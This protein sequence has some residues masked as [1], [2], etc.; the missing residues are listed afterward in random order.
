MPL[1]EERGD[2][3]FPQE[4]EQERFI[5]PSGSTEEVVVFREEW[6]QVMGQI[7][8]MPATQREALL[9]YAVGYTRPEQMA[10]KGLSKD[11][12]VGRIRDARAKLRQA[13][14]RP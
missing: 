9:G 1:T 11:A 13:G 3:A 2:S 4:F 10:A 14:R 7:A 12:V 8:A 5:E 6:H